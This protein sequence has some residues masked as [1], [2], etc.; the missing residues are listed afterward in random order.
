MKSNNL[1]QLGAQLTGAGL[2]VMV[3][4]TQAMAD[5]SLSNGVQAAQPDGAS[6]NLFGGQGIFTVISN[7]LIFLVGAISVIMLI[8]GGL[9]Y[10]L[11]S[12]N[13]SSVEGAKNTILYAVI[14]IIVAA[15]AFAISTFVVSKFS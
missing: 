13:S 3:L 9:R 7:T 14:G 10:V 11:S 12:G 5:S 4:A 6:N 15:S 2:V 1:K 8:V